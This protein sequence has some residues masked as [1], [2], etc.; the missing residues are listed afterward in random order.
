MDS[1]GLGFPACVTRER[2]ARRRGPRRG[3]R[4]MEPVRPRERNRLRTTR[5]SLPARWLITAISAAG[6]HLGPGGAAPLLPCPLCRQSRSHRVGLWIPE[7]SNLLLAQ[8][9]EAE[10]EFKGLLAPADLG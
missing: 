4:G 7:G 9:Q 1:G 2:W 3:S 5:L 10:E 6:G 8:P